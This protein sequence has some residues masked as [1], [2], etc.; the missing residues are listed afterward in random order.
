[1]KLMPLLAVASAALTLT[2][3]AKMKTA[4]TTHKVAVLAG[5]KAAL[6]AAAIVAGRRKAKS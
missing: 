6:V 5:A 3:M 2:I 4:S 1:M